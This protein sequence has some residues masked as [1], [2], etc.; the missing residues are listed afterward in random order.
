MTAHRPSA[1]PPPHCPGLPAWAPALLGVVEIFGLGILF[2]IMVG[3]FLLQLW[4]VATPVKRY[5]LL[6]VTSVF[7]IQFGK[8]LGMSGAHPLGY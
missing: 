3:A 5:F 1:R 2:G 6:L 7:L 4:P 8:K